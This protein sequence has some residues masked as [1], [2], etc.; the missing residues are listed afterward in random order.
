M[1]PPRQPDT[2]RLDLGLAFGLTDTGTVRSSNE[3]NLV[4]DP[5]LG[6]VAVADGMGGHL[7]GALASANALAALVHYIRTA[8]DIDAPDSDDT[9]PKFQASAFDPAQSDPDATW[10]DDTMRA[11]IT[12]H[13]AVEYANQRL[14]Q[15][16]LA[17]GRADGSGMGTTLTG[18]WQPAPGAP[19]F[20]FHVGDTR[21]YRWRAGQLEQITRD[22]TM[23]Q[24]AIESGMKGNLPARN[25]LL[26]AL[27]PYLDIRPELLTQPVEPGDLYLLCSD[28]LHSACSDERIASILQQA[29]PG[30]LSACCEQLVAAAK[31]DGSRDNITV[32]L[33]PCRA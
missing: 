16:N 27:G 9:I 25:L 28:G 17:N 15:A 7:D 1:K 22:Q 32:V 4:L 24:Q 26:Q 18:M 23:Y 5:A 29:Q 10:T 20:V 19:V 31:Q 11:M 30:S 13:G 21:L 2:K 14:F 6:L 33:A 8:G 12:L 3:D